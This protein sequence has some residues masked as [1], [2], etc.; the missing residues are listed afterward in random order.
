MPHY[1]W[2]FIAAVI[3]LGHSLYS[4]IKSGL[5]KPPDDWEI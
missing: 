5:D 3:L 4:L 1:T 2:L